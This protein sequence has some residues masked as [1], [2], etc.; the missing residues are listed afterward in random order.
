MQIGHNVRI[1]KGCIIVSQVGISGSTEIGEFVVIGGQ[2]GFAGHLQIG[3]GSQIAAKSGVTRNLD[4]GSKVGG[5]PAKP[6]RN[7]LKEI[8]FVERLIKNKDR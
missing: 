3:R 4:A 7:W 8:A 6:L 2:A 5:F 1:G